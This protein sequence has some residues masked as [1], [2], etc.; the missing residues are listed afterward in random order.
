MLEQQAD[1]MSVDRVEDVK[2]LEDMLSLPTPGVVETMR[3]LEGDLIVLGVGGKTG[4]SLARMARRASD[5]AGV[6]RRV[7]GVS[8][9]THS[10][11]AEQ[12]EA[13]GI[14]TIGCDLLDRAQLATLPEVPNVVFSAA[15][16]FGSTGNEGL[17]W[18][19]NVYLPGLVAEKYAS[20]RMVAYS[21]GNVYPLVPVDSEG[22]QET[23]EV[24][25]IGEYAM[26]VLGRER[27]FTH[28]S[29]LHG[30]PVTLVRLYYANEM[31]Y[32][33]LR[34]VGEK[35]L[36]GEPVDVTM[37]CF[38][39][40]WQ[41]DS[42]AMTLRCFD[43]VSSPPRV[44]NVAGAEKLRV[45]RVAERFGQL[46]GKAVRC[47]GHEASDALLGD[48]RRGHELLGRPEVTEDKMIQW[49]A[50]WLQRGGASL[51]KPTHFQTRDGKF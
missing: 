14:E 21:S 45:R 41:G 43:H 36:A 19:M 34:D 28:F 33:T 15:R 31:R 26:S 6:R 40:I 18:A 12:L 46:F 4:P 49:L 22:S 29:Q 35:V 47:V 11:L 17:T 13:D 8:R 39:A 20:S 48:S 51:Q 10:G 5:A 23:D 37:G 50:D 30:T 38:N 32:G 16:K 7:I 3:K 27:L 24:G 42:N 44:I 1:L 9:F 25:P 2:Q